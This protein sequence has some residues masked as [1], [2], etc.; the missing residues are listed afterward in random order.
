MAV[1]GTQKIF[2]HRWM[3]NKIM[4]EETRLRWTEE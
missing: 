2:I 4:T 1:V 3:D